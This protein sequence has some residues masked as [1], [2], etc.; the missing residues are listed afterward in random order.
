MEEDFGVRRYDAG[1][2]LPAV[3]DVCGRRDGPVRGR[4]DGH[5]EGFDLACDGTPGSLEFAY[6]PA[7]P[8]YVSVKPDSAADGHAGFAYRVEAR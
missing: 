6:Q 2:P 7:F 3:G 1:W 4:P 8:L 5:A